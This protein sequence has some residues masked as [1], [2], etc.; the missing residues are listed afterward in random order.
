MSSN[1][2]VLVKITL[3]DR[4][5]MNKLRSKIKDNNQLKITVDLAVVLTPIHHA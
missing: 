1:R 4:K 5:K 2:L 3:I